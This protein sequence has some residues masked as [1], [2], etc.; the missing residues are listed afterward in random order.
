MKDLTDE[1]LEILGK[2]E[3]ETLEYKAVLPPSKLIAQLICG[4]ANSKGGYIILG[5]RENSEGIE[6]RGLS[7]DFHAIPGTHKALDYCEPKPTVNYLYF[8]DK[9]KKLYGIKI[10]PSKQ[11]IFFENKLFKRTVHGNLM[12]NPETLSFRKKGFAKLKD[13]SDFCLSIST[14]C[15]LS[16]TKLIEH[17]Q[18]VL[19]IFDDQSSSLYPISPELPTVNQEGKIMTRI[20]FS[21]CVDNFEGF[22]SDLLFE[23]FLAKPETLKSKQEVTI[24][25]VLNCSDIQEFIRYYARQKLIKLQKGSVKGFIKENRQ[26]S[27][28]N[29]IDR[30]MQ[31][32]VEAI[33]QIRHLYAHRNGII[34]EKFKQYFPDSKLNTEFQMSI[35]TVCDKLRYLIVV[36][37]LVDKAALKTYDLAAG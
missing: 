16:K 7:D 13:F 6:V 5:I 1:F 36:A 34:D 37:D 22:L 31:T 28:L 32:H 18:S 19:K 23:I 11:P 29:V 10:E 14:E 30:D 2:P 25:E 17:Y 3:S 20:L 12:D 15:T 33:L 8:F 35:E 27:A 24:E 21:S 9:G 26:I 4:F